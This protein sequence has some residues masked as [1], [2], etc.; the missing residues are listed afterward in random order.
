MS[1][2]SLSEISS[3]ASDESNPPLCA[4]PPQMSREEGSHRHEV[5]SNPA[6]QCLEEVNFD[7]HCFQFQV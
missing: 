7:K 3:D 1:N 4:I 5:G 6:Y 2:D